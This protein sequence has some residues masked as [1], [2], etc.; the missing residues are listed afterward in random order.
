MNIEAVI[1]NGDRPI[2]R[3]R[4]RRQMANITQD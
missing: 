3:E 4:S 1:L 2:T